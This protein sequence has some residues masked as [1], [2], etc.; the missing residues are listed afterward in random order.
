MRCA[1]E[2]GSETVDIVFVIEKMIAKRHKNMNP[3]TPCVDMIY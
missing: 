3:K 1:E 2:I